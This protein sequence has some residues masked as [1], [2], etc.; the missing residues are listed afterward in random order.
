MKKLLSFLMVFAPL[1]AASGTPPEELWR[2]AEG[3]ILVVSG[4]CEQGSAKLCGVIVGIRGPKLLR[5]AKQLCGLPIFWDLR[6][7]GQGRWVGG[8]LLD[9]ESEEIY[10]ATLVATPDSLT[11]KIAG[12]SQYRFSRT[13]EIPAHCDVAGQ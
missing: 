1:P 2:D 5:H 4:P 9:P 7:K 13:A 10:K 3:S 12:V 8:S 6:S 11:F